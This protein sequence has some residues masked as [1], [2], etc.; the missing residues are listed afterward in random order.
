MIFA[1]SNLFEIIN[2]LCL[3]VPRDVELST[4]KDIFLKV[5]GIVKVHN[6]RIWSLTTNKT[7]LSA[8]LVI[9]KVYF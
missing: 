1:I 2:K 8:H 6:L 4:A 7:A 3:G 5:P 9:G